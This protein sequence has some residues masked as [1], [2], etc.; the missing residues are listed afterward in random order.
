M[1][2]IVFSSPFFFLQFVLNQDLISSGHAEWKDD[3]Q[4]SCLIMWRSPQ[5]LANIIY[6]YIRKNNM[7]GSVYTVFE[8]HSGKLER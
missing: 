2:P 6:E 4:T 5:E 1:I 3:S 7:I 8:L